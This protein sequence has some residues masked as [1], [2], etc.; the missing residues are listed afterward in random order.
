MLDLSGYTQLF[1]TSRNTS[2][3]K[4]NSVSL[5]AGDTIIVCIR[6]SSGAVTDYNP[7]SVTIGD[8]TLN[9]RVAPTGASSYYIHVE[10][11]VKVKLNAA[12]TSIV[13][14]PYTWIEVWK[15][16]S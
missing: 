7:R 15:K 2:T 6:G 8:I 10:H 13:I 1:S 12:V 11:W 5:S 16:T 14:N 9:G 4:T 3:S